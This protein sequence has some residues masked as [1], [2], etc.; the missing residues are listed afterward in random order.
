MKF[1]RPDEEQLALIFQEVYQSQ[2][3]INASY[4]S[5]SEAVDEYKEQHSSLIRYARTSTDNVR[6][7]GITTAYGTLDGYQHLLLTTVYTDYFRK[8]IEMIKANPRFPK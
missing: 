1:N 3:T 7:H 6:G 4:K 5:L 8:Q 2:P